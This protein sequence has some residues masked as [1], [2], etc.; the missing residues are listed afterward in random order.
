MESYFPYK[1]WYTSGT[2]GKI[3]RWVNVIVSYNKNLLRISLQISY[4]KRFDSDSEIFI[5]PKENTDLEGELI[6]N[7]SDSGKP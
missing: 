4:K 5:I 2:I 3:N 7:T 6:Y 1:N